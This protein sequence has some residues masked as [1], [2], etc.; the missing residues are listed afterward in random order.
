MNKL[1][2]Q[3]INRSR[4]HASKQ[5]IKQQKQQQQLLKIHPPNYK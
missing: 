4:T 3:L 5:A 2:R 1:N